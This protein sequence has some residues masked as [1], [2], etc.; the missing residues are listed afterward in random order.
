MTLT[1]EAVRALVGSKKT[2]GMSHE[3]VRDYFKTAFEQ[4]MISVELYTMAIEE[5]FLAYEHVVDPPDVK[6]SPQEYE[7]QLLDRLRSDC[8]YVLNTYYGSVAVGVKQSR[9]MEKYLWAGNAKDQISKMRELFSIL[10]EKPEWL[11]TDDIDKYEQQFNEILEA[12]NELN[13]EIESADEPD[14]QKGINMVGPYDKELYEAFMQALKAARIQKGISV[15]EICERTG[16]PPPSVYRL[17]SGE[18]IPKIT[19]ILTYLTAIGCELTISEEKPVN[20]SPLV[21]S[22]ATLNKISEIAEALNTISNSL[23]QA[24]AVASEIEPEPEIE[25]DDLDIQKE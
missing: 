13:E 11:T 24:M 14:I 23:N 15:K 12:D 8:E 17:E 16:W 10:K 20:K 2:M 18:N 9:L 1:Q 5:T 22:E 6:P 25:D 4:N 19:T 21:I 7:Y 3:E